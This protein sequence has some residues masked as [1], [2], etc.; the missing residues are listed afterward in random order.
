MK[1]LLSAL[2]DIPEYRSLLTAIDGGACPA[3]VAGLSAVHRAHF[4]AGIRRGLSR[5]VAVICADEGEAERMARD[6]AALSGEPIR[7]LSAR[8]FTFHNAAVV[9]R[10]WEHKRLSVLRALAAGTCPVLVC[11]VESLLQRTLPR[12][13]LAQT[14][15]ILRVGERHDLAEL[16][17]TLAA[18]GYVRA[19][20]VEGVG[21]FALR[22]GI[23]DFFSPAHEKPV[24]AEFWGDEI[25]SLGLFDIGTQRRTEALGEAELLPAA[26][27][28]PQLAP[29]GIPGLLEAMDGLIARVRKRRGDNAA[30]LST[31]EEDR[32]RLCSGGSFPALDRYLALIYP[33]MSTAA[34][35]L[36]EDAVVCFSESPRVAERAE[37]YG[38]QMDQDCQTLMESGTVAG[39]VAEFTRDF[40]QLCGVLEN[41]PVCFLDSF[42]SSRYPRRPKALLN[43]LAK[44]LPSYGASL[45]TA[46]SDLAHYTGDGFR[47]VVLV[48]SEQRAL[49]LQSLLREQHMKTAVDF[50]LHQLPDYGKAVIAVGG[51]TAG[52]E[53]PAAHLAILTEGQGAFGKKKRIKADRKSVV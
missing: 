5:P 14:S 15:Q 25:D 43:L 17:E 44:Q 49:N 11:T 20:Q 24:R 47:T 30:L 29:G 46:V 34:D 10:Q 13:L 4:A 1:E 26:E 8:E 36:P 51:L 19:E 21:Q 50:Q 27:V 16:A 42:A 37:H 52:L 39:E 18:A 23:L 41:W 22:G 2:N 3:A 28:L 40:D 32:E 6:L 45:E 12:T 38:W 9:S 48:S 35:Y 33:R 31:L 7:T 53:Y